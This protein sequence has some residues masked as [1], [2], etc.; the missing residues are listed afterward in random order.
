MVFRIK[1]VKISETKDTNILKIENQNQMI[2][3]FSKIREK[4]KRISVIMN[5]KER[6]QSIESN[7]PIIISQTRIGKS[8]NLTVSINN[9]INKETGNYLEDKSFFKSKKKEC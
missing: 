6:G 8:P 4:L 5:A 1:K 3:P 2:R 7:R 9:S